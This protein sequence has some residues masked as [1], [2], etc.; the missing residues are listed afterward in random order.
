MKK[1][2]FKRRIGEL[3]PLPDADTTAALFQFGRE[4][5]MDEAP[6]MGQEELLTTL[7]FIAQYFDKEVLQKT[8]RL[9]NCGWAVLT[10]E[11]VSAAIYLQKG[12]TP[13]RVSKM[14]Y[15][16]ELMCFYQPELPDEISPLAVCSVIEG[17]EERAFYC[18]C[19]DS[20]VP[21]AM[22]QY[23]QGYALQ[24]K[25]SVTQAL[26]YVT[27]DMKV[28]PTE[29]RC[30]AALNGGDPRMTRAMFDIF[31]E[32]PAIA[33]HITFDVDQDQV[34]VEHNPLWLKLREEQTQAPLQPR[35]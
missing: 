12:T 8:Y 7:G 34:T 17:G 16:G 1:K 5:G 18:D 31:K 9:I 22:L 32:C 14:A 15:D 19:F 10:S 25:T 3:I 13:Q 26:Q 29:D 2:E 30:R 28:D 33:A 35:M 11:M 27:V 6:N 21:E 24:H 23:A 4:C 20:L